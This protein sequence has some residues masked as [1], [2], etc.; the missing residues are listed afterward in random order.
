MPYK[1][2]QAI[3]IEALIAGGL[4]AIGFATGQ[5]PLLILA[6]MAAG[7][8]TSWTANVA[9]QGFQYW[10]KDW[11]TDRGVL[12]PDIS[13]ALILAFKNAIKVLEHEWKQHPH[14]LTLRHTKPNEA[15]LT[16][17]PFQWL[18][19][20][21]ISLFHKSTRL[22]SA[23]QQPEVSSVM[24]QDETHAR[25]FF[26]EK[27]DDYLYGHDETLLNFLERRLADAWLVQFELILKDSG[28]IGTHA[29]RAYQQLWQTSLRGAVNQLEQNSAQTLIALNWLQAWAQ[30]LELPQRDSTGE[31]VL[32]KALDP[33]HV[34]LD[35]IK[36][37]VERTETGIE[38]IEKSLE[39]ID[40]KLSDVRLSIVS[41]S[42]ISSLN[43]QSPPFDEVRLPTP[44]HFVGR[45]QELRWLMKR[46]RE[47]GVTG[48]TAL[49][50]MGGIG[51]TALAAVAIQR[52]RKEGYFRDGIAVELCLGKTDANE[53]VRQVLARFE[54]KRRQPETDDL[55]KL[56]D[57]A[58]QLLDGKDALIVLDNVEPGLD[59]ERVV[60]PLRAASTTLLLTARQALPHIVVPIEGSRSLDLLSLKAAIDL[61]TLSFGRHNVQDLSSI[62]FDAVQDII[63][64][65]DRHTLAVKL[66]GAY[67]FDCKRDLQVL[68]KELQD[69]RQAL[70][71]PDGDTPRAVALAFARSV[72]TL[73]NDA[74]KLFAALAAFN[75]VGFGR[76]AALAVGNALDLTSS[77][78]SLDLLVRRAL[79]EVSVDDEMPESSDRERQRFHPLIRAFATQEFESWSQDEREVAYHAVATYYS[80]YADN[81]PYAALSIDEMNIIGAL[82]WAYACGISTL[83]A[84]IC[85]CL[86]TFWRDRARTAEILHYLP[87][88]ME[89]AEE[90][91]KATNRYEDR[92]RAAKLAL[93]Y[94][95]VLREIGNLDEAE[96]RL[97]GLRDIFQKELDQQ[98]EAEALTALGQISRLRGQL[99]EAGKYYEQSLPLFRNVQDRQGEGE[100]LTYLGQ[101]AK[102]SGQLEKAQNYYEQSLII[103]RKMQNLR[104]QGWNLSYLGRI[105]H[106]REQLQQAEHYYQEALI[107]DR[108]I[109]DRRSEAWVLGW[110]G[111]IAT[112]HGHIEEAEHYYQNALVLHRQIQDRRGEGTIPHLLGRI[113]EIRGQF[114][115]AQACYEQSLTIFRDIQDRRS[116]GWRL[117]DLGRVAHTRSRLENA[118]GQLENARSCYEQSLALLRQVHDRQ[119]EA[120]VLTHFGWFALATGELD[121]GSDLLQQALTIH[122]EVEY[123]SG[124]CLTLSLLSEIALARGQY[125]IAN[126]LFKQSLAMAQ[127]GENRL[128]QCRLLSS[129]ALVA[130]ARGD[131]VATESFSRESQSI[132][133][134]IHTDLDIAN[135]FLS[136]SPS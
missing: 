85:S 95:Q 64:A 6:T 50:G 80:H 100:I 81:L 71:L 74:R 69:P 134:D 18:R 75:T 63:K 20:D 57:F 84:I 26:A 59:V 33:V 66:A 111:Q 28:E 120:E 12:N 83:V 30:R 49:G 88:G 108:K 93:T 99:E 8:G 21:A 77:E 126:D 90:M 112:V 136:Y 67:A 25:H 29:W 70:K 60:T 98:G 124:E 116:I 110:L 103:H 106:Y 31:D 36:D 107:I 1:N 129:G 127:K 17:I 94:A 3:L 55:P 9:A 15:K 65:L 135:T 44:E 54:P 119:G 51:K 102:D 2:H 16:L 10:C 76:Q 48:I 35:E 117:C 45:S 79:V 5:G 22:S 133:A 121:D 62:E 89:A 72:D 14:Y 113:A 97:L 52:L 82:E 41:D 101:I 7:I 13:E 40:R 19:E 118:K 37:S 46:L 73:T 11:V 24:H 78:E 27:L 61:F 47:G 56:I 115:E 53:V 43:E 123:K 96:Q 105:A 58:H 34:R 32:G 128:L 125:G 131:L 92:L 86:H 122:R 39:Q 4:T 91:S 114:T 38:R 132:L 104:G 87:W 109:Q 68:R 23:L 130:K 42:G